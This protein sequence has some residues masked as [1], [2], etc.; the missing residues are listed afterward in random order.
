[1]VEIE[2]ASDNIMTTKGGRGGGARTSKV[3]VVGFVAEFGVNN[4]IKVAPSR[5]ADVW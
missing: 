4:R 1:M 5:I 2:S 3:V